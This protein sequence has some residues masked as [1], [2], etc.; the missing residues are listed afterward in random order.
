MMPP[1]DVTEPATQLLGWCLWIITAL[2]VGRLTYIGGRWGYSRYF[3]EGFS[4][5]TTEIAMVL[6]GT[7]IAGSAGAWVSGMRWG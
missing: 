6:I 2:G 4:H 5:S 1:A 3:Q 7:I